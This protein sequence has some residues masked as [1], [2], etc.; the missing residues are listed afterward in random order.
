MNDFETKARQLLQRSEAEVDTETAQK[1]REARLQALQSRERL[2][3]PSFLLPATGMATASILALVLV[4]SPL[5]GEHEVE[6]DLLSTENVELYEDLDF[7][8]WLASEENN[9]QG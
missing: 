4:Y 3:L 8:Y 2:R 9:L 6:P 7:Y 5:N 1:L